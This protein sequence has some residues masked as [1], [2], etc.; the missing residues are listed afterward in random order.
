MDNSKMEPF[1]FATGAKDT[2]LEAW[3]ALGEFLKKKGEMDW[4]WL[5]VVPMVECE[6]NYD[7]KKEAWFGFVSGGIFPTDFNTLHIPGIGG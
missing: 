7:T 6:I 2:E 5:R 4:I 1:Y 3:Q